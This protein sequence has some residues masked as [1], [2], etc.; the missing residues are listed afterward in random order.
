MTLSLF[1]QPDAI[2]LRW[3]EFHA[4]HPDVM[5]DLVRMARSIKAAGAKKYGMKSLF[6]A[7]RWHHITSA[8]GR[9]LDFTL[10]NNFTAIYA[11]EIMRRYPD[12][13]GFFETR[14]R[15]SANA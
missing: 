4:E 1:D 3:E 12:L 15:T 10:N 11:R 6:E 7:L 14:K 2:R 9:G 8:H 5:D 13:D